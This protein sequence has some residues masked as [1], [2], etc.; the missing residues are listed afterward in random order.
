MLLKNN[1]VSEGR[2]AT[3]QNEGAIY[4]MKPKAAKRAA[5][6]PAETLSWEAALAGA[7]VVAAA[8]AAPEVVAAASVASPP[9]LVVWVISAVVVEAAADSVLVDVEAAP[10]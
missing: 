9:A 6:K 1:S 10:S 3:P 5:A 7:A 8:G 2:R 4:N